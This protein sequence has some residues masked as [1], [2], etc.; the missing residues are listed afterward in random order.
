MWSQ[1]FW[2]NICFIIIILFNIIISINL[3]IMKGAF[4]TLILRLK[5]DLSDKNN[6][7]CTPSMQNGA[8]KKIQ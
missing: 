8:L 7:K 6:G 1:V 3:Q 4:Q 5:I 2:V